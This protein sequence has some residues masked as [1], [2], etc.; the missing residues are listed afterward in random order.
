ML[1]LLLIVVLSELYIHNHNF[2]G[3]E[4]GYTCKVNEK[5]DVY[6]FGVVLMELV[7]GKRPIEPEFGESKNIVN[8]ISTKLKDREYSA[9][10]LVDSRIPAD[11]KEEA[12][13]VLRIAIICTERLPSLRPTMR[14]VVQMLEEAEPCRLGEV[15]IEKGLGMSRVSSVKRNGDNSKSFS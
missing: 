6:S 13:K 4:Y 7:T 14:S 15:D 9:L 5:S 10:D 1:F 2:D 11:H 12:V 8:W 3:A